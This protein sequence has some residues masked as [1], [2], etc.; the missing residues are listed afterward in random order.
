[1]I[2]KIGEL[3]IPDEIVLGGI[4]KKAIEKLL[5]DKYGV[6]IVLEEIPELELCKAGPELKSAKVLS[7]NRLQIHFWGIDVF[8]FDYVLYKDGREIESGP[9]KPKNDRPT[10]TLKNDLTVGKHNLKLVGTSCRGES[11][12]DFEVTKLDLIK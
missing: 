5:K 10:F 1:M 4:S 8:E 12:L 2:I 6:D 11:N 3:E 9:V 7:K